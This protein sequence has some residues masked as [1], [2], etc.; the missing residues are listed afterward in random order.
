MWCTLDVSKE[1][2]VFVCG[3]P[4]SG[5]T[6]LKAVLENHPKLCGSAYETT[7]IFANPDFYDE[8]QWWGQ[9]GLDEER[10]RAILRDS[11]NILSF[12]DEVA[13]AVCEKEGAEG[14]V[15]KMPWPYGRYRL[16]YVAS[17]FKRGRWIHIIRD[18]RDCYCS[19]QKHPN[20]PQSQDPPTFAK[21][22]QR[23]VS[24]HERLIPDDQKYTIRYEDLTHSPSEVVQAIM[25][26]LG[27]GF[28]QTQ[29]EAS[30]RRDYD[31]G[32]AGAHSR[33]KKPISDETVGR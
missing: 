6:L 12:Y 10:V 25:G 19:A 31:P 8:R 1:R 14:Y 17:K 23:C 29:I 11:G 16:W 9:P 28:Q 32:T 7:G 15:D 5:T 22:W 4:R 13:R 21:Y 2:H 27:F 18:G 24:D 33:L 20:V 30:S 26:F 3:A